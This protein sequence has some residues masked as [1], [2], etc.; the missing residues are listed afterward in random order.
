MVAQGQRRAEHVAFDVS[1]LAAADDDTCDILRHEGIGHHERR[2]SF[3]ENE[4]IKC[5]EAERTISA[6]QIR[7]EKSKSDRTNGM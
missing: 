7:V 5:V 1:E 4:G 6:A 3:S 2:A